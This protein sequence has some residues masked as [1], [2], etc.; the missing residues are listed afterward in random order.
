MEIKIEKGIALPAHCQAKKTVYPFAEMEAGDSFFVPK[1][2]K[3]VIA[4]YA[5]SFNKQ[6]E[7]KFGFSYFEDE[8]GVRIWRRK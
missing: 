8:N 3:N 4:T 5:Y 6:R 1:M 7:V 2:K